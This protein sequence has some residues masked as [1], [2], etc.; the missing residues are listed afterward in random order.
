MGKLRLTR[1]DNDALSDMG[2]S[3]QQSMNELIARR[4]KTA[5]EHAGITQAQM[6]KELG[7]KDHQ[8][9]AAVEAGQRKVSAEELLR[10]LDALKVDLEGLTDPF[11]LVDEGR[12]SW[13]LDRNVS[14]ELLEEFEDRAGRWIATYL[15][16]GK[17]QPAVSLLTANLSLTE[18]SSDEDARAAA[19]A[20]RYEW[21][22]GD[23]PA[24][25]LADR[26]Q[27]R[28][29]ALVLDVDAPAGISGA[30]CQLPGLA[31][32]L[33]NRNEPEGR[34]SY[35]LANGTFQLLTGD[36][37]SPQHREIPRN[38]GNRIEQLADSFASAFLMPEPVLQVRWEGRGEI[39]AWLNETATALSVTAVALKWRLVQ[40]GWLSQLDLAEIAD[41]RLKANAQALGRRT[42]PRL[43]SRRFVERIHGALQGGTLSVRRAA[44]LLALTIDDL[45]E[46]LGV[47]GLTVPFDL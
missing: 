34:R 4:L 41:V 23:V 29:G 36:Q 24:L 38:K 7:F 13:C 27:E 46:L 21:E 3:E 42:E 22:L 40:L 44:G 37:M 15:K 18:T 6:A 28:L 30:V 17:R 2:A 14:P 12:F 10:V 35:D 39:H 26:L 9:W 1:P 33:L 5:R 31:T 25:R 43:F 11:R 32:I 8:S 19:E 20:L 47:Y 16:L 45:A